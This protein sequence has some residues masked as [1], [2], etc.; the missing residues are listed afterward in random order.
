[1][2]ITSEPKKTFASTADIRACFPAL[3]R[4]HNQMPVAYFDGPG[5]TQ[6]PRQVVE[7]MTDYLYHHNAN[8][9][10]AYPTSEETDVAIEQAR[11]NCADLLNASANEIA[12]GA[13][14]TTLTFHL[15]RA[16]GV[17]Y[18]SGDEI[19]VTELDHHANVDPWRRLEIERGVIVKT[20]RLIPETGQLD[21]DGFE[22]L[23]TKRTKLIAIGAASNALGTINDVGRAVRMARA[24]GALVFVDAVHYVP[25]ALPD[26]QA[27][28]CDFLGMSAYKF[29]G[30]HI[31]VMF[32]KSDLLESISFPKL[33]PAPEAAPEN[34]ETGT[35]NHEG[36]VG[37]G[38]AV[39][40]LA[41]LAPE[42][43]R[44]SRLRA[45]YAELHRRSAESN[46]R[47]WEGLKSIER[48][49]LYGPSP[50]L[51][52]TPTIAFT[53]DGVVSTDVARLLASRGLFLSHGD[54]YAATVVER[55][56]L[57]EEGLVRAGCACYTTGEEIDRLIE[58][59][60]DIV[61][62]K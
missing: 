29:Y 26:V 4:V 9:H 22:E 16:L 21:W 43:S 50:E 7:A 35:Q 28:D 39:E 30:P 62:T 58:S 60:N 51:P 5:G 56:G 49:R 61:K 59:V 37:A 17:Q 23:I 25:H 6:V 11:E 14:M 12:F 38:A 34:V 24:I 54:F 52:R 32:G 53:V 10:W 13:N 2:T 1:M 19:V 41:S 36:M 47:L 57:G 40:F 48:V 42:G 46:R 27:L 20:A 45:A 44:R 18:G 31:G 15:A 55:L 8:T 33:V 3:E